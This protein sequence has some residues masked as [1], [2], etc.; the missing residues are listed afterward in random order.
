MFGIW[1][2]M[3]MIESVVYEDGIWRGRTGQEADQSG[4][5]WRSY[6]SR[7]VKIASCLAVDG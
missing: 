3:A 6:F 5:V 2:V 1:P 7:S 4:C